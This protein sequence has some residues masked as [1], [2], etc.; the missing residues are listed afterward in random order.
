MRRRDFLTMGVAMAIAARTGIGRG[1][2][3]KASAAVVIGVDKPGNLPALRGAAAGARSVA[4]WLGGEGFEIRAFVDDAAPVTTNAIYT[5]IADLVNRGTLDQLVVYFAGHGFIGNYAE[6][7]MLSGA[8]ENPNEAISLRESVE[9]A[10]NSAI[11]NVVFISDA[12]RSRP[13][14]LQTQYVR[15]SLIFPNRP[16]GGARTN[17]DV[18]L[19]TLIGDSSLEVSVA[20]S[21]S[22]F[23]G[24]YTA[25]FL[26][27]FKRPDDEM[28]RSIDGLRVVPNNRL[29]PYLEREVVKRAERLAL[30]SRQVPD[31]Q[32]VSGDNTY[33]SPVSAF[34]APAP[35][36][37]IVAPRD[38]APTAILNT[39]TVRDLATAEL[40]RVGVRG[41][42]GSTGLHADAVSR[43]D[44][45]TG[46]LKARD[47]IL[48]ASEPRQLDFDAG[49]A[50]TGA[51]VD[52]AVSNPRIRI[53][54]LPQGDKQNEAALLKVDMGSVRAA[55]V[56][57]RFADG[58][59]TVI[60][61]LKG[62]V[63]NI[64]VDRAG[65]ANVSY[66]PSHR[67]LGLWQEYDRQRERIDRLHA[68][69]ATSAR[70]GVFRV[71]A[72]QAARL[73]DTIRVLK[74]IDPTLGLYAAYAYADADLESQ[75][76]SVR[77]YLRGDLGADLFDV[78]MLSG[79][80]AGRRPD[81]GD[82]TVPFCPMLSQGWGFLRVRNVRVLPEVDS[83]QDHLRPALWTT[84]DSDGIGMLIAAIRSGKLR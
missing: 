31:S 32:V 72:S 84:F 29:E 28:V 44:K 36:A 23:E 52:V 24:I 2:P 46:F 50:I 43:L 5:A 41:L 53:E 21:V 12:C 61:A 26:S 82:G 35:M 54:A 13:D 47:A 75:V 4:E 39:P 27:A 7:W 15:G 37:A 74:G 17:V 11:P 49:F 66:I 58:S 1:A 33:I 18:F 16:R 34:E 65:V 25:A 57:I 78:A 64:T 48:R 6:F 8:P 79:E 45:D 3:S 19:A 67:E 62:Y 22:R 10:R 76:R 71:D 55:S 60:A 73:A 68:T 70:Y 69:V 42:A 59:G 80:L 81:G 20:D 83:A 63:G 9:L 77:Q 40:S 38:G 14:S 30:Q 56:A 51:R